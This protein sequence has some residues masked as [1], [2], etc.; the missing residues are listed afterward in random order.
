MKLLFL[1]LPAFILADSF[2]LYTEKI[3]DKAN[4]YCIITL[5]K[6]NH[7]YTLIKEE[8]TNLQSLTQDFILVNGKSVPAICPTDIKSQK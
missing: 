4:V 7:R 1:L 8:P 5:C 2:V 6:D 3:H